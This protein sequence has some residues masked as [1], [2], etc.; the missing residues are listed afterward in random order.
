MKKLKLIDWLFLVGLVLVFLLPPTDPDLGWQLRC[1]QEIWQREGWCNI[2]KFSVLLEG[3]NWPNHHWLY[4]TV[5]W[6]IWGIWS[7][8]AGSCSAGGRWGLS[9]LGAVVM[10][11]AFWFWYLATPNLRLE[12][13]SLM[14]LMALMSWGVF[15]FGIRS[16]ILGFLYFNL[17]LYIF[18]RLEQR[19]KFVWFIPLVMLVWANT[20]GGSVALG[21]VLVGGWGIKEFKGFKKFKEFKET[22]LMLVLAVGAT[23]LNP[24]GW[25]IYQEAWR[26]FGPL[27]GGVDLS[28]QI[29]EW[30]PPN[31]GV[32]WLV[33]L[34]ALGLFGWLVVEEGKEGP[35]PEQVRFRVNFGWMEGLLLLP[36]AFLALKARRNVSF[37]LALAGWVAIKSL[38]GLK[39]ERREMREELAWLA[40][41]GFLFYGLFIRLPL[42]AK[43]NSSWESYCQ[44]LPVGCPQ[45]AVEFLKN[46]PPSLRGNIF[47]RYEWGGFLIWQLP[48]YKIFVDG[49]MP[50][51][52]ARRSFSEGGPVGPYTLYLETL[53]TQ[54]S[55]EE[56]LDQYKIDWILISPGTFMDLKL[57]P[58]P[59]EFG[60]GVKSL[61]SE[62]IT[63]LPRE[64]PTATFTGWR[65]VYR[66]KVAVVYHRLPR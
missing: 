38:K 51:W 61:P 7:R 24:F 29:A 66:D 22:V 52:L 1:G 37:Y 19:P 23:L 45:K 12:K 39:G 46:Q 59:Q 48:E 8:G 63:P 34:S 42:T 35:E 3:Y 40:A 54:P 47:N 16:Q 33:L 43:A 62:E 21:L 13:M 56:T 32:W 55:W 50:A 15:S 60:W 57:Q 18:S 28:K 53:Q 9:V 41:L 31:T 44:Q 11:L 64:S 25:R 36:F 5:I 2:N 26:H 14:S 30:V 10:G 58:N 49:R 27:G 65:E 20:H 4:Q 17:L 6:G